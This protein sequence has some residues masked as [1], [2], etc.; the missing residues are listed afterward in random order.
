MGAWRPIVTGDFPAADA[1][2]IMNDTATAARKYLRN[3]IC[4]VL[5]E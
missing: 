2:A 4:S 1:G 3:F 5:S